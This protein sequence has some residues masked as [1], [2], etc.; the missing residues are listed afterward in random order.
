MRV[1]PNCEF[2]TSVNAGNAPEASKMLSLHSGSCIIWDARTWT[3]A[4]IGDSSIALVSSDQRLTEL[5]ISAFESLIRDNKVSIIP[6]KEDA[7]LEAFDSSPLMKASKS[8]L[9]VALD[10]LDS[11]SAFLRDPT[12]LP[13]NKSKRTLQRWVSDSRQS[14]A[15]H[16]PEIVGLLPRISARGNRTPKLPE[17]TLQKMQK[18]IEEDYENKKS[19]NKYASWHKLKNECEGSGIQAPSSAHYP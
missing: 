4:N 2:S 16:N 19:K 15:A 13:G 8:D 14:S 1:Y 18:H 7:E 17:D 5:A 9:E 6:R 12:N 3:V 10:R 11:V